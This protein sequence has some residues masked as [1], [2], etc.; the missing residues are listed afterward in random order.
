MQNET[1]PESGVYCNPCPNWYHFVDPET[2]EVL[3]EALDGNYID[4]DVHGAPFIGT[5]D[6][7]NACWWGTERAL[8]VLSAHREY[9]VISGQYGRQTYYG[10]FQG[11]A[12]EAIDYCL[13]HGVFIEQVESYPL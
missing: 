4:C 13:E 5:C 1:S 6:E 11:T 9:Q 12:K 3:D 2:G 7:F 8:W 10:H